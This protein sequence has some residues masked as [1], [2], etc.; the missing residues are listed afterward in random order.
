MMCILK[1]NPYVPEWRA[2]DQIA[3]LTDRN[4]YLNLDFL[5]I[6]LPQFS[7]PSVDA[8]KVTTFV[9]LELETSFIVDMANYILEPVNNFSNDITKIFDIVLPDLDFRN[10]NVFPASVNID[11]N[12]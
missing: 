5:N 8:I 6:N 1:S 9:N 2:G 3:F 4:G 12:P 11:A 10:N 7:L